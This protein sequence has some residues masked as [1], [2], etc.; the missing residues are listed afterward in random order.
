MEEFLS[1]EAMT[2]NLVDTETQQVSFP[3]NNITV[4]DGMAS[5]R[6]RSLS[7][8]LAEVTTSPN[9]FHDRCMLAMPAEVGAEAATRLKLSLQAVWNES[10]PQQYRIQSYHGQPTPVNGPTKRRFQEMIGHRKQLCMYDQVMQDAK[11]LHLKPYSVRV[12][13]YGFIFFEDWK[14]DLWMKRLVR[15]QLRYMDHIQCAAAR[16]VNA[17]RE[18][19]REHGNGD[20]LYDSMHIRRGDFQG[21]G[22]R[23]G[24]TVPSNVIFNNIQNVLTPNSTI[25]VATDEQ[26][27]T[28]F[29]IFRQHYHV[30]FL[31][32]FVHLLED[33]NANFYGLVEQRIASRGRTFIAA[34]GSSFSD[35]IDRMM[36]YHSQ[37][38]KA[39]GYETGKINSYFYAPKNLKYAYQEYR[40]ISF[41]MLAREFPAGWRDIDRG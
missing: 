24:M 15:D 33:V 3:P 21:M 5:T 38:E 10:G 32:D 16:I 40:S 26:N 13:F 7:R 28:F 14:H 37:L 22:L 27:R 9:W 19:A 6:L 2:G 36:G 18:K 35:Y 23:L 8:W 31:D 11:V 17:L 4:W 12:H 29:D 30:Y 25:Y 41:P 39:D 34:Y 1:R 20:G